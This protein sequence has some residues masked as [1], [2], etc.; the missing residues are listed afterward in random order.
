M[1]WWSIGEDKENE[2]RFSGSTIVPTVGLITFSFFIVPD[3]T[4]VSWA[5]AA[6][7]LFM[8]VWR[9]SVSD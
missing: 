2:G 7:F 4:I 1:K 3:Q 8:N 5:E 9:L 6:L